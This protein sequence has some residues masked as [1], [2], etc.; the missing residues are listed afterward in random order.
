V[1]N[2]FFDLGGHSL[3]ATQITS[4]LRQLLQIDLPLRAIFEQPTVQA[5]AE[6]VEDR[7][8]REIEVSDET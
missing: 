1:F 4:R 8:L 7:L 5:L 3:K 2:N 6:V